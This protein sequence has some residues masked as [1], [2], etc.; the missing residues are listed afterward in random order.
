MNN[1]MDFIA[2]CSEKFAELCALS[3]SGELSA[4]EMEVLEQ[5]LSGCAPCRALLQEYS[6]LAAIGMAKLAAEHEP[7]A[8]PVPGFRDKQAEGRFVSALHAAQPA[9]GSKTQSRLHPAATPKNR[10]SG[11]RLAMLAAMAACLLLC[12]G[13]GIE[14]GR[15]MEAHSHPSAPPV[16][17]LNKIALSDSENTR[18]E[19]ELRAAK[20][21]LDTVTAKSA[22][23][24]KN[25]KELTSTKESLLGQIESL[26]REDTVDLASLSA[27]TQQRDELQQ[28]LNDATASLVQA[29]EELN[30]ARQNRQGTMYRVATLE[31]E[32]GDLNSELAAANK[33]SGMDE[34]F[35][36]AD[37]DIRDLMGARQLYISDVF[38][39][40]NNG[41]RSKPFGRVF[42]TEGKSLIFYAFD[43]PTQRGYREAKVFQ[44][45]G[46]P[47]GTSAK[48]ISIGIFY[49][50]SKKNRRWVVRSDNP[51]ILAE[52]NSVFVTVEP[53]GGSKAPTGRPFLEAYLHTLPPNHP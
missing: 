37:R 7:G 53:H 34:K 38:D 5:H 2:G 25:L 42:Y 40:Q 32:I 50:D 9:W 43:L 31:A 26:T 3:T 4:E 41:K 10:N 20:A 18:I 21:S 17:L 8:E 39:V 6:S 1:E 47:D 13:G 30:Q 35:L 48:P 49:L 44:A 11:K 19:G 36:A 16:A 15:K 27:M 24:E 29:K 14:I 12:V 33:S 52:I 28:R 23:L 22:D 45:W 46:K 51:K